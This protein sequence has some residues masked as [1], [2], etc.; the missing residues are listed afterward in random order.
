MAT[1]QMSK[2][3]RRE[4]KKVYHLVAK[5]DFAKTAPEFAW[6]SYLGGLPLKDAKEFNIA[7]LEYIQALTKTVL[8]GPLGDIKLYLKWHAVRG[9]A[10][11]LSKA[12]VDEAFA[13]EKVLRGTSQQPPRWKKCVRATD[14]AVGESLAQPFVAKT[15]GA[16]GKAT[17]KEMIAAIEARMR[18]NLAKTTWM[19]DKTRA[20]AN[21][22]LEKIANKIAFP[23]K[24]R[25]YEG[26]KIERAGY[27]GNMTRAG[28]FEVK[29]QLGKIG[30]PVDR[31]EWLMT[32][33][34][35]NAYYDPSMNEMVF[36]AGILQP[37]FYS[38]KM[39]PAAN[40]GAIGMVMGHEL[41]HG[42]DDEG[43]QFD[44]FGNLKDWW[45]P[46]VNTEFER[47]AACVEKQ[48][49]GYKILDVSLNGKLTLGE[50]IADLGGIKLAFSAMQA[51]LGPSPADPSGQQAKSEHR[52]FLGYAQSW[53]TKQREEATRLR[54]AT[55]PH[56]PPEHRVNGPL[57]NLPE[58]AA[59]F[60]CQ[61]GHRMVRS[62]R[63]EVW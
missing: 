24:W 12:F 27:F 45:S 33:P 56:S 26:L 9:A 1:L 40:F 48:F 47:R 29:R 32:P 60:Q 25:S 7:Q 58:F 18:E 15:L 6:D 30:K 39:Q 23:D 21:E 31:S 2:E 62:D 19:D 52:F 55:D 22:K 3:D 38:N 49:S 11:A 8:S 53:C 13:F 34:T 43:R 28:A 59:A 10:S 5:T 50:N 17:V 41:T 20:L 54:A 51:K 44:A 36:P 57:S 42:F 61:A 16:E 46:T 14:M 63:C 37:P 35:V 4:P